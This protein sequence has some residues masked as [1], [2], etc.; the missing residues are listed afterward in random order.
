MKNKF[1]VVVI[2]G[3][4]I[5]SAIAFYLAKEKINVA[6]LESQKIGEKTTK[7]AAGMLGAHSENNDSDLFY[8]FARSSQLDY[9]KLQDEI[10]ELSGVNIELKK[11][12][13]FKLVFNETEKANLNHILSQPTVTWYE[14]LDMLKKIPNITPNILGAAYIEEDVNVLPYSVCQGFSKSAQILGATVYEH[15]Q[16]L[17]VQKIDSNYLL[18]TTNGQFEANKVVIAAGV[19]S[20]IFFNQLGLNHKLVPVKGECIAVRTENVALKHT[21]FHEHNYIV[22][23]NNGQLVIGATMI[24]NDWDDQPSLNGIEFLIRKA[25]SM[26]PAISYMKIDSFWAGLRP[27]TF[28]ENPFIGVHPEDDHILFAT[29]HFRNGILLAPATAKIIR[30]FILR[31]PINNDWIEAFKLT[32]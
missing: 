17:S 10:L 14:R 5:G 22:P 24:P 9:F 2:G 31:K 11:G 18:K 19:W 3:G 23:R 20:N 26:F 4:I 16:V 30:D 21:L 28:D 8:P 7:A 15:T 13:I 27:Q 1:D 32:R 6:V 29:G 12:G 25:K